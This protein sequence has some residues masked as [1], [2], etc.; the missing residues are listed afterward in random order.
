MDSGCSK[1]MT[2]DPSRFS[3]FKSKESGFVTFGD[4]SKGKILGIGDIGN[5]YSP[6]IKNVLLVDNL[7]HN[8][9]SIS[10]LCDIGFRVVFES[11]KC[12]IENVSTN[13][14]IFLGVRK[15]NVYVIDVDSFDSKNK[16]L[17]VMNDNSWLWHRRLGHASMDSISKLVR[18]DLVIG[19]PSIPFVKDKLC[20]AC[21]F[22]KQIKTSFHSKKEISTTRPL[23]LLHI[24]LFGP[25]RIA[26]L[27]GK[28]YAFVI[29]DDF[30]RFTWVIFL[31]LKSDVLENFVKFCKNVQ[32]EK[33]YSITSVRSDHGGEFDND[34][35]ELF[36]D[37]HGFN[38]NFSAPR[39][40]QQNG[41]VERKNRTIQEMARSMLN[42][43]SLPKYFWAEA[44]NTS[45]YI[46]NRVFIRPNMNKTPYELWKGRKPNIGY[47]RVFGCKCFILN[48]KDNLGKFDAKSDVGIFIGY[49]TH[50]KAY[51][52]YNKRTNVVEESIHVAFD[53][54]NPPTSKSLDD[55]VVGLGDEVQNL[56]IGETSNAPSQTPKEEP[57]V[58][59][60]N[61]SQ[62]MNSNLPHEWKFKSA[63]PIDQILG[64]PS[65]GVTTRNSLRNLCNFIAFISQIEP[66]NFKEAEVD[67]FWLLAMQEE[68]NQ[69]IRNNV[70]ELVP[71]PSHQS[72]IG[73]KWVYRNKVDEHGVIVRNKARLVAQGYNQEE[74]I[75]YEETFAPVAR[76][77]SIRM[78][79]A[80][81]CHKNFI[82]Y[83]M[84][85]KSAFL[86]G[87]IMEEVY[88]SQPPG[89]QNHKYPNHV[90]KL[91]KA[92]YGL[93]QA[94]RAWYER[95]STFLISNG[96]SMG[97]ADNTLFIKR[98]SKDI[99]IVQIYV[100]DIIFGATNDALCEE[101]SKCMHSEFEMSMM[102]ELNFFLGLQIKQQKD[103]IF[104]GQTKYIKD[105]LQ[106]FDLANAKSMN[107]PMSTSIKMDKDESGKN[108]DITKYRGMIGSLLYLTASRPDIL[109]S[110]GL[111]AR[112]QSCPKESHLSAV[113]RIFRYLIGT[114]N[115]GLWYPK[116]SNF[117][118]VSYSDADFAGCKTD[119]KST[120]GTCHFLGNSLVSWFSKKQNSVALSTT[121]AEY[122]AAGSCCA[123][124]LWMKQTLKDFDVDFECIPIKCDNTSAINLSKNPILHSRAKHI[125]IRHHFLR[126]HIQR[127]EIVLDFV[128]T[129]F[130]LADIFT[131]PLSD[132]RFSFIRRE[133]G[134]T[135]LNEI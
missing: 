53:E 35:L 114:M 7:K 84:D 111:C 11:S 5:I 15:D 18:K 108:V 31:T 77:E 83:Q 86:N 68:I 127:G 56:E 40:P 93:K 110:V 43:I 46:L 34:A 95:L 42:E 61:E 104:I 80:F 22:G 76:L 115:L 50:S 134:M 47:F 88:V 81:A 79:L 106:K 103:G 128:S 92:L 62:G 36:C 38:H 97:K 17:T 129:E 59:K 105:L 16:C 20:D 94:P 8:L 23:Q 70:W 49:S 135:N 33:G 98:K 90:Y 4:N 121:E 54:T 37:D 60:V 123:Q 10:Q 96:F 44:V 107:T 87:Y 122:I 30:S 39:T 9:L 3:S 124:I 119:R 14:V 69:F 52:I 1:H 64:D 113:K 13:E 48:T 57:P 100:D 45:C 116:N 65:Q 6:C 41:V 132:E 24:D 28:Y 130:Q 71:R 125:D 72:V 101:F 118:I 75:D 126:D 2:G 131:K 102:G 73:T 67:E 21:Q 19:L 51:R 66:K 133:L 55:D 12:S 99:I 120:S 25:S 89:F 26:S 82:L 78:L 74:G 112:Y 32:N 109:F 91:K 117:E 85:V 63:H 58:E 27:G 29:V